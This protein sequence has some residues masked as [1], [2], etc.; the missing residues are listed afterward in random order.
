MSEENIQI[1][2]GDFMKNAGIA[3]LYSILRASE[4]TRGAD[5]GISDD[6][7]SLWLSKQYALQAD[8]TDLYFRGFVSLLASSTVYQGVLDRIDDIISR[9]DQEQWK[10]DKDGKDKLKFIN[11]KL[12]SN[13]YQNGFANIKDRILNAEVYEKLKKQKLNEKMAPEEL[14]PRLL[15]IRSFLE[16]PLCKETFVMKS[17]AYNYINRFWSDKCFLLR[18]NAKKDMR[19]VFEADF[20]APL[21][22]YL[23]K[24]HEKSKE[25]CIECGEA[26]D[27]KE[28]VSI[29]F[30]KDAGD[31]LARK[32]SAFWNCKVDAYLCPVCAFLYALSPLGFQLLGNRF[33]FIN[34][35][36]DLKALLDS[37]SKD[38]KYGMESERKEDEKLSSWFSRMMDILLEGKAQSLYNIQVVLKST[39][40]KEH[41]LFQIINKEIM[42]Q[43]KDETV[44]KILRTLG[45]HPYYRLNGDVLNV[46]EETIFNIMQYKTQ[47]SLVN[48]LL[49]E[50]LDADGASAD[51]PAY[52]IYH[53][54]LRCREIRSEGGAGKY[55]RIE[56]L[57]DE[58]NKLR[59]ELTKNYSEGMKSDV[60]RGVTYQLL[61]ALALN[62]CQ[63]FFDIA[64]RMYG[65]TQLPTPS[66]FVDMLRDPE[67]FQAGGYAFVL[68]LRGSYSWKGQKEEKKEERS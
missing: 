63:K 1:F 9:I 4:A 53:I 65:S 12:L 44:V 59:Q 55:M 56:M 11:E 46:Y 28:K 34:N 21:K 37:N 41:Y 24:D 43:L 10:G 31:D 30:M 38:S 7:Q 64:I 66:G 48:H 22:A 51:R 29:A 8:W 50:A 14:K 2:M 54:E 61:N 40:D 26:M 23:E 32:Q 39:D 27:P 25:L 17:V 35:N 67:Q 52:L 57:A 16:Q 18:S 5:Y 60:L 36:Y 58:G 19:E 33:L 47:Y 68:G 15:E 13:S 20:S 42:G 3:G 6:Q 45:K 49:R 62:N